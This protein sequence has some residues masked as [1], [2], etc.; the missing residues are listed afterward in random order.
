MTITKKDLEKLKGDFDP[1]AREYFLQMSPEDRESALLSMSASN[2]NRLAKVE[3]WQIDYERDNRQYRAKREQR[4]NG[5]DDAVNIT[6]K[7]LK[8]IETHEANKFNWGV[9]FRDRV[10]PVLAVGF[11]LTLLAI[12][13]GGGKLP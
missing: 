4:E 11:I 3:K 12:V 10:L 13:Y 2:S 5:N 6:Q 1:E 8:A 9:W 7:I